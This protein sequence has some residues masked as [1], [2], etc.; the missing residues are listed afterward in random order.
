MN[1]NNVSV[2]IPSYNRAHILEKTIPTYI[3]EHVKEV[4][5]I[6]DCSKDNTEETVKLLKIKFPIIKYYRQNVNL[7]QTAAKNRGLEI[8]TSEWVYFGDDDSILLPGSIDI[9]M[10]TAIN[11]HVSMVGAR[12][13]YLEAGEEELSW[14]EIL[15]IYRKEAV[16]PSDLCNVDKLIASLDMKFSEPVELPFCQ[17]CLLVKT[18][19]AR[20]VRFDEGYIGTAY[21]EET[22]FIVNCRKKGARVFYDSNAVQANLPRTMATGGARSHGIS[23]KYRYYMIRNN[24]YFLRKNFSFLKKAHNLNGNIYT[25]QLVYI[26]SFLQ[27]YLQGAK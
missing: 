15:S 22:D 5:I 13:L 19:L 23:W 14:D 11:N 24:W 1:Q 16:N 25:H 17:A 26:F 2:I 6:D 27:R 18:D 8:A 21:R 9:L 3:Q 7:K 12:A 20:S 4:I 10:K